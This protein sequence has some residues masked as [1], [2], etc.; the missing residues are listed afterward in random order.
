MAL[1]WKEF[2]PEASIV[3]AGRWLA[4]TSAL[5][6][7]QACWPRADATLSVLAPWANPFKVFQAKHGGETFLLKCSTQKSDDSFSRGTKV[8]SKQEVRVS[9]SHFYF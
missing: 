2:K 8:S 9:L 7:R 1:V 3:R 4:G 6:G 5:L